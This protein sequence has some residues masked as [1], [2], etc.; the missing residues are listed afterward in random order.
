[1]AVIDQLEDFIEKNKNTLYCQPKWFED[2]NMKVYI[3]KGRHVLTANK[4]QVC[5][6]I[7]AVEVIEDKRGQ[8]IFSSFLTKAHEIN[9]WEATYMECVNNTDLAAFLVK[10]GWMMAPNSPDCFFLIKDWEKFFD[11]DLTRKRFGL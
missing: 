9:P 2:D 6:D 11:E 3:R 8:G 10:N 5:L 7:A 1:M 4:L